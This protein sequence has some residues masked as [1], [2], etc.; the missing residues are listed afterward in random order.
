MP[1]YRYSEPIRDYDPIPTAIFR[2]RVNDYRDTIAIPIPRLRP[3]YRRPRYPTR[4]DTPI[5]RDTDRDNDPDTDRDTDTDPDRDTDRDTDT[6]QDNDT[7]R[8]RD[9]DND[10]DCDRDNDTDRDRDTDGVT[11]HVSDPLPIPRYR[12]T[13]PNKRLPRRLY[14]YRDT[15]QTIPLPRY[16][17]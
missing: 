11:D 7:D 15:G 6:D 1:R 5:R 4:Y 17:T 2:S 12:Q 10:T 3:R 13:I 14:R 8:D 9:R 16:W